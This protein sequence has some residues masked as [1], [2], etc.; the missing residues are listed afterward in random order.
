VTKKEIYVTGICYAATTTYITFTST[1]RRI[2]VTNDGRFYLTG[3]VIAKVDED[4]HFTPLSIL[5][6]GLEQTH[7]LPNMIRMGVLSR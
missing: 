3:Y 7:L 5:S 1:G 6:T 2:S 4:L